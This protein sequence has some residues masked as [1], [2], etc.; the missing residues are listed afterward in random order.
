MLQ[1]VA[2]H[3]IMLTLT[4]RFLCPQ[5]PQNQRGFRSIDEIRRRTRIAPGS[6]LAG[7]W[8]VGECQWCLRS[9]L[10]TGRRL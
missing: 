2:R 3:V 6:R 10:R 4:M 7:N 5:K 1:S 8:L 9:G